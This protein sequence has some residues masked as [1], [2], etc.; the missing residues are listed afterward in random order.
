MDHHL[1][2]FKCDVY[3]LKTNISYIFTLIYFLLYLVH[4]RNYS[5]S[6]VID[7]RLISCQSF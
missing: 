1:L 7:Y 4:R 5:L 2:V 3:N 6:N